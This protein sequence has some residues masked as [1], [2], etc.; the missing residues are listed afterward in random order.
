[1]KAKILYFV[2]G[3]TNFPPLHYTLPI[4]M[5]YK[6]G[7]KIIFLEIGLDREIAM[8]WKTILIKKKKKKNSIFKWLN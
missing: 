7:E 2:F 4:S 1:M 3:I 8:D 5:K 6:L